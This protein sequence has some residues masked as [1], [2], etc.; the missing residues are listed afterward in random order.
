MRSSIKILL[1][2]SLSVLTTLGLGA[3]LSAPSYAF[4]VDYQKVYTYTG[5]TVDGSDMVLAEYDQ[6]N[7]MMLNTTPVSIGTVGNIPTSPIT[8]FI[9]QNP[10][11]GKV[12]TSINTTGSIAGSFSVGTID[13]DTGVFTESLAGLD[14]GHLVSWFFDIDGNLYGVSN[15]TDGVT[16]T[17]GH[18][19]KLDLITGGIT[20]VA[21]IIMGDVALDSYIVSYDYSQDL[22]YIATVNSSLQI[23]LSSYD[24]ATDTLSQSITSIS[25]FPPILPVSLIALDNGDFLLSGVNPSAYPAL[26]PYVLTFDISGNILYGPSSDPLLYSG[27]AFISEP[28]NSTIVIDPPVTAPADNVANSIILTQVG[29]LKNTSQ[30]EYIRYYYTTPSFDLTG[31]TESNSTVYFEV[32]GITYTSLSDSNGLFKYSFDNELGYGSNIVKY[33]YK[34]SSD[35][36][37]EKKTLELIIGQEYFP[38]LKDVSSSIDVEPEISVDPVSDNSVSNLDDSDNQEFS[39]EDV[40]ENVEIVDTTSESKEEDESISSKDSS[41]VLT[42]LLIF[43]LV[44]VI[45]FYIVRS[46]KK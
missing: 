37:S 7:K 35:N 40:Q 1:V 38:W 29:T 45:T 39:N 2:S 20:D 22:L 24:L 46:R 28:V 6:V 21:S 18:V 4:N 27:F 32:D 15:Y 41:S 26:D 9:V 23:V 13:L 12:Y 30:A 14:I 31:E 3:L 16:W 33:W 17:A 43:I 10:V 5:N 42:S 25:F 36:V 19:Y 11:D 8:S 44:F 34:D